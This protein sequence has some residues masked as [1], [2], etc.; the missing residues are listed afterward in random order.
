MDLKLRREECFYRL[1][2]GQLARNQ[3]EDEQE[4]AILVNIRPARH[5]LEDRELQLEHYANI[6]SIESERVIGGGADKQK[7]RSR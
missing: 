5:T 1:T 3:S 7:E 6:S 4:K 2:E